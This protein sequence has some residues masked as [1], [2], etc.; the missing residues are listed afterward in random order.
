VATILAAQ[1]A[2]MVTSVRRAEELPDP[3]VA[4]GGLSQGV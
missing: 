3:W 1:L 4:V 2:H